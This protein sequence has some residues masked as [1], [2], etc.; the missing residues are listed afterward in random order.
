MPIEP[1]YFIVSL[2]KI[3]ISTAIPIVGGIMVDKTLLQNT[4]MIGIAT[5]TGVLIAGG[6][7]L[8]L[9]EHLSTDLKKRLAK[10]KI[11]H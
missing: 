6:V 10:N 7:M 1:G 11:D 2:L 8:L 9:F 4:N 5:L 3:S